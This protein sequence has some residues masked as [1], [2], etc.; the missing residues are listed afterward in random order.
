MTVTHASRI[1][2]LRQAVV[3]VTL[4]TIV[5]DGF[6]RKQY[7]GRL[8]AQAFWGVAGDVSLTC[9][10]LGQTGKGSWGRSALL[11]WDRIWLIDESEDERQN[12]EEARLLQSDKNA[13]RHGAFVCAQ[14]GKGDS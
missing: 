12:S 10:T 14:D 13:L 9:T 7:L 4:R 3:S 1:F 11:A 2:S 6:W 5:F 8:V